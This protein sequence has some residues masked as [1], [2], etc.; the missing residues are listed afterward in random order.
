MN[1]FGAAHSRVPRDHQPLC[2]VKCLVL[3]GWVVSSW[4][5]VA[6]FT[7]LAKSGFRAEPMLPEANYSLAPIPARLA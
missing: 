6:F 3:V 7:E 1:G 2:G 5:H 4:I